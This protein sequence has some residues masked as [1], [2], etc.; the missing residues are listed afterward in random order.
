MTEQS[1]EQRLRKYWSDYEVRIGAGQLTRYPSHLSL[2]DLPI[3]EHTHFRGFLMAERSLYGKWGED[4]FTPPSKRGEGFVPRESSILCHVKPMT[5]R[6]AGVPDRWDLFVLLRWNL[7]K[8]GMRTATET[9]LFSRTSEAWPTVEKLRQWEN[10]NPYRRARLKR[11]Y[12]DASTRTI[13]VKY[14]ESAMRGV[15]RSINMEWTGKPQ[16]LEW[17]GRPHDRRTK[18]NRYVSALG[19]KVEI[20]EI[21]FDPKTLPRRADRSV[22]AQIARFL[23]Q[24]VDMIQEGKDFYEVLEELGCTPRNIFSWLKRHRAS[25]RPLLKLMRPQN[26]NIKAGKSQKQL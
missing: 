9:I 22:E 15:M 4:W 20:N 17:P 12:P 14:A 11:L 19:L 1:A 8:L 16:D 18:W 3:D 13:D 23:N 2:A 21:E 5:D 24:G 6:F 26:E 25:Y 10:D 7:E